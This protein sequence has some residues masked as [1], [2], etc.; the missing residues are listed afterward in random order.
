MYIFLYALQLKSLMGI[1]CFPI[2]FGKL[3]KSLAFLCFDGQYTS[4]ISI[5]LSPILWNRVHNG[6]N[7]VFPNRKERKY[8]EKLRALKT[9]VYILYTK[10]FLTYLR[11]CIIFSFKSDFLIFAYIC[12]IASHTVLSVTLKIMNSHILF[13]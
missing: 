12:V 3:P 7:V 1:I 8:E 11:I 9:Y 6:L 10:F 5:H 4:L 13:L 2:F